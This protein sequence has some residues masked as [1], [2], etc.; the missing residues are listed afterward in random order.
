V[1]LYRVSIE[2][3]ETLLVV[4]VTF[5]VAVVFAYVCGDV[6]ASKEGN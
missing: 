4:A 5:T 6:V 3:A 1:G 2:C